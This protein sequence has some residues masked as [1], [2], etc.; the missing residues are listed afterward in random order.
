[1][2]GFEDFSRAAA[3]KDAI[4]RMIDG[5]INKLRP[6]YR[7][8]RV[9]FIDRDNFKCIVVMNGDPEDAQVPVNMGAVQPSAEG[10]VVRIWGRRGDKFI[11][12][13][14]G[15]AFFYAAEEP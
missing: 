1:M 8:A 6:D 11:D 7:Y 3:F 13:V 10:Q 9:V 5:R 2:A 4:I 12:D 14:I 15:P